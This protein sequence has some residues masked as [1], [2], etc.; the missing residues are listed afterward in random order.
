MR[1]ALLALALASLAACEAPPVF[2]GADKRQHTSSGRVD[3]TVVV[4]TAARGNVILFLY[5]AV[6][7]PPPTGTGRPLTFLVL[8]RDT[9]FGNAVPG[10]VGPFTAPFRF[11]LVAPGEYLV[12]GF[13]DANADFIPWY[14]VTSEPNSGDVGGVAVDVNRAPRTVTV[15]LDSDG[16]PMA[17]VDVRVLFADTLR[18]PVDRPVFEA[19]VSSL[20]LGSSSATIELSAKGFSA[21]LWPEGPVAEGAPVFLASLVDEN[22]DGVPDDANGDGVVDFWPRVVVRKVSADSVLLDENDLDKN[23]ILDSLDGG[24]FDYEHV[25]PTTGATIPRDGSPD[26]VVLAAGFDFSGLMSSL[27]DGGRVKTTPTPVFKLSLVI[28]PQALDMS[29][30][31]HPGVLKSVPSGRYA[32]TVIQSTGQTWRVPNELSPEL[33][34][35]RGF[36]EVS[37]QSFVISVP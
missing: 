23:G 34:G 33:A 26:L 4:N 13:V 32:V 5:D 24:A 37:S 30:P 12:R 10:D 7:P 20:T 15:G 8:T 2:A 35:P 28:R 17:A 27:L 16:A 31:A 6:R 18:V 1:P 21:P 22:G 25:N 11:P 19:S 14:S 3:G 9:V 36:Y 29:N